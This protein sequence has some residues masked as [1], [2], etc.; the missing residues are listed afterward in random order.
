M[1]FGN[2][3]KIASI[4][5][6]TTVLLSGCGSTAQRSNSAS[7]YSPNSVQR[8]QYVE[9]GVVEGVKAAVTEGDG[10]TGAA[11]G[12]IAGGLAGTHIGQGK[13]QILGVIGGVLLGATAGKSIDKQSGRQDVVEVLVR[14]QNGTLIAVIQGPDQNLRVGDRVALI[15]DGGTIRASR[16]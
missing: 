14:K 9:Y 7:V 1:K 3:S 2:F 8:A 10:G 11:V 5:V 15:Q 4:L 6:S 12:A 16:Q 13:G